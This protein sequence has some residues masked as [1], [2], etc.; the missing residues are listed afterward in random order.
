MVRPSCWSACSRSACVSASRP[1]G[2]GP[3]FDQAVGKHAEALP[4]ALTEPT[5]EAPSLLVCNFDQPATRRHDLCNLR[6]NFGLEPGVR[7]G[8]PSGRP[9]GLD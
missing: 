8:Q 2:K 1:L 6:S 3:T 9:D 7:G 5:L 4:G